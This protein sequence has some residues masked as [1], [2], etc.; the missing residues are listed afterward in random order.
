MSGAHDAIIVATQSHK[1]NLRGRPVGAAGDKIIP[2]QAQK[3]I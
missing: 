3:P 1:L 2:P